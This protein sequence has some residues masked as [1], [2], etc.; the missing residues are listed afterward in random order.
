MYLQSQHTP[1]LVYKINLQLRFPFLAK[2]YFQPRRLIGTIQKLFPVSNSELEILL[3][4][5]PATSCQVHLYLYIYITR[6]APDTELAGYPVQ[7]P[8]RFISV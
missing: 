8:L 5:L 3:E 1:I 7:C 4:P 2:K 6:V